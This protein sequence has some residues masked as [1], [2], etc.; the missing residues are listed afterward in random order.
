[1]RATLLQRGQSVNLFNFKKELSEAQLIYAEFKDIVGG[2]K[3][4]V[5]PGDS[6]EEIEGVIQ[7]TEREW[8]NFKANIKAEIKHLEIVEHQKIA[9]ISVA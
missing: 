9:S 7:E 3:E 5:I 4:G 2:I 1:M 6:L 8:S